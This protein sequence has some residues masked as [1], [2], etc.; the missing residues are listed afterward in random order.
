MSSKKKGGRAKRAARYT[1]DQH[2]D[3]EDILAQTFDV[4]Q[5]L[6]SKDFPRYFIREISGTE[7]GVHCTY[8]F[9]ST[10]L[11]LPFDEGCRSPLTL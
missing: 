1:D 5:K 7:V 4:T 9:K 3:E 2:D 8:I 6:R 11:L 10:L